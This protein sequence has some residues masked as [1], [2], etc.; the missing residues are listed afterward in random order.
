MSRA[1]AAYRLG[2]VACATVIAACVCLILA[3][4]AL[5]QEVADLVGVSGQIAA[6]LATDVTRL[7]LQVAVVAIMGLIALSLYM[8]RWQ[9]RIAVVLEK[10][11]SRPCFATDDDLAQY[12]ARKGKAEASTAR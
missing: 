6:G 12:L 9:T 1:V 3:A 11:A 2:T 8:M 5:G 10:L 7:A 4:P